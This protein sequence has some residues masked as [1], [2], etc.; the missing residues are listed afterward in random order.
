MEKHSRLWGMRC[1]LVGAMDRVPDHGVTWRRAMTPFL[2]NLGVVVLDPS[3]KP[4]SIGLEGTEHHDRR[5]ELIKAGHYDA[6]A[7]EIHLLRVIDLR[8]VDMSDFI[9]VNIDTEAHACGTYEE[10]SWANRLKNPI[11]IHCEQGK[12]GLPGWLW[13]MIPHQHVFGT[14]IELKKYLYHVHTAPEVDPMKRWMF[15]DYKRMMPKVSI[16]EAATYVPDFS[17]HG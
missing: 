4:I 15:F 12:S 2:A 10:T 6:A 14:W 5:R 3:D 9:I 11:L 7:K 8:M 17:T 1:Y 13:G 16:E